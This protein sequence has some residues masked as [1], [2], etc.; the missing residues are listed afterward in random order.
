M[1]K[2]TAV[3][4]SMWSV[5]RAAWMLIAVVLFYDMN[6]SFSIMTETKKKCEELHILPPENLK[7]CMKSLTYV[8]DSPLYL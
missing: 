7:S 5:T 8:V 3:K 4:R 2:S 1:K 6:T